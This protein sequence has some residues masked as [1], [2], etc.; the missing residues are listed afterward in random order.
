MAYSSSSERSIL[1]YLYEN[2]F[3]TTEVTNYVARV[4]RDRTL[5]LDDIIKLA[6]ERGNSDLS[7]TA[8]KNGVEAAMTEIGYQLGNGMAVNIGY[9]QFYSTI[10]GIFDSLH[11]TFDTDRHS[12]DFSCSIGAD[13]VDAIGDYNVNILGE[14]QAAFYISNV[15]DN[16]T[17]TADSTL[18]AG[19][20]INITGG[21]IKIAGDGDDIGV[22]FVNADDNTETQAVELTRN[23]PSEVGALVPALSSGS[24]Y[25][26]ITT[27]YCGSGTLLSA[28]RSTQTTLAMTVE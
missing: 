16:Y 4:F 21:K 18:S 5:T 24:Y 1:A 3:N 15:T 12:V 25:V 19:H 10:H 28:S 7:A 23:Y 20:T 8:I 13:L 2:P 22:W 27:Q 11:D 9:V 6:I 26:R 14:S 17:G